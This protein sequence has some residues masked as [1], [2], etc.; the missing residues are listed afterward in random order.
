MTK[1]HRKFARDGTITSI[2][3]GI[4]NYVVFTG[5]V[6]GYALIVVG[7]LGVLLSI[8]AIAFIVSFFSKSPDRTFR[9]IFDAVFN[10]SNLSPW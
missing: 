3:A 6:S 5:Q 4:C 10:L 1:Q 7:I 9:R 8:L 2:L